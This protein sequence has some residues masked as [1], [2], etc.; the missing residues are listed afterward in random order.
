MPRQQRVR[1]QFTPPP[2]LV[3][4]AAWISLLIVNAPAQGQAHRPVL[5]RLLAS[6]HTISAG[7]KLVLIREA[8]ADFQRLESALTRAANAGRISNAHDYLRNMKHSHHARQTVTIEAWR[9]DPELVLRSLPRQP[10]RTTSTIKIRNSEGAWKELIAE[11]SEASAIKTALLRTNPS[12]TLQNLQHQTNRQLQREIDDVI[13]FLEA[14]QSAKD[15]SGLPD[16]FRSWFTDE[17]DFNQINKDMLSPQNGWELF[18]EYFS[19]RFSKRSFRQGRAIKAR[20][21]IE[22]S[23]TVYIS[24]Q[25]PLPANIRVEFDL[26]NY[27]IQTHKHSPT[28]RQLRT[29]MTNLRHKSIKTRIE[30]P[31]FLIFVAPPEPPSSQLET[32]S[33]QFVDEPEA[34]NTSTP[35]TAHLE[36]EC[37]IK[38]TLPPNESA[39]GSN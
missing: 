25:S 1:Q 5:Q 2:I 39:P 19:V 3:C 23:G 20:Y 27:M 36:G 14:V 31:V 34:L 17:D 33:K 8:S 32:K 10:G 26:P 28:Y 9:E 38:L 6:C 15:I 4:A 16:K 35:A 22:R 11:S 30:S 18:L 21:Q 37:W 29:Q 12:L 7:H 13:D 24:F